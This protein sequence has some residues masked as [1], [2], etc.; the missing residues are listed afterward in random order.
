MSNDERGLYPL[1]ALPSET[2]NMQNN[3]FNATIPPTQRPSS[4]SPRLKERR[5]KTV[6]H[7][8]TR[9]RCSYRI[10]SESLGASD[11]LDRGSVPCIYFLRVLVPR[12]SST[13]AKCDST[14]PLRFLRR[15]RFFVHSYEI[16]AELLLSMRL[17]YHMSVQALDF[18]FASPFFFFPF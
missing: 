13:A 12:I 11:I 2:H 14:P 15:R 18:F 1:L 4:G 5:D 9:Q 17:I 8:L 6:S 3:N 7:T 16:C 10:V